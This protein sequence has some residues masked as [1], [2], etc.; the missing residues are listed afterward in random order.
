M[1]PNQKKAFSHIHAGNEP[2]RWIPDDGY[3]FVSSLDDGDLSVVWTPGLISADGKRRAREEEGRFEN[4]RDCGACRNGYKYRMENCTQ[5]G[6][7]GKAR[8]Y[9]FL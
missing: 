2:N 7:T 9:G 8:K 1:A 5:C 6:K 4:K 3:K